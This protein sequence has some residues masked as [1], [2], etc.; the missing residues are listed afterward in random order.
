M[1]VQMADYMGAHQMVDVLFE[2]FRDIFISLKDGATG[3]NQDYLTMV[4]LF[5]FSRT[6][7]K[8]RNS[9][10]RSLGNAGH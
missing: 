4:R 6:F 9:Q 5:V 2:C 10:R 8:G 3:P 1:W 7:L